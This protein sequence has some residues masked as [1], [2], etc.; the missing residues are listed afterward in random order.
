LFGDIAD[1][2]MRSFLLDPS[3]SAMGVT[4]RVEEIVRA[5]GAHRIRLRG[6]WLGEV[7]IG[8]DQTVRER[9]HRVTGK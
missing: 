8:D 1:P 5:D 3:G 6:A 4:P 9:L 2:D 7:V